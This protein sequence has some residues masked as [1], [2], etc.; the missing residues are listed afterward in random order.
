MSKIPCSMPI[1]N[2]Q[3]IRVLAKVGYKLGQI[4]GLVKTYCLVLDLTTVIY[5]LFR[6]LS[7]S[8]EC[9]RTRN[10]ALVHT[11]T[12]FSTVKVLLLI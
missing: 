1:H 3:Q 11:W 8:V 4:R 2:M 10:L 6:Q 12:T 7:L 5:R 9:R